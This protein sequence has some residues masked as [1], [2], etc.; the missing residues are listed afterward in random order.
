MA[1]FL[2][3][4]LY[5]HRNETL[6]QSFFFSCEPPT[7]FI[8][9]TR[10]EPVAVCLWQWCRWCWVG[11]LFTYITTHDGM[12]TPQT[13]RNVSTPKNADTYEQNYVRVDRHSTHV[14]SFKRRVSTAIFYAFSPP[15]L[16]I[17]PSLPLL[18]KKVSCE[19]LMVQQCRVA[20]FYRQGKL[21]HV[22]NSHNHAIIIISITITT[23]TSSKRGKPSRTQFR[24]CVALLSHSPLVSRKERVIFSCSAYTHARFTS[25]AMQ[26]A[27][28]DYSYGTISS[29]AGFMLPLDPPQHSEM[30]RSNKKSFFNAHI[31]IQATFFYFVFTSLCTYFVFSKIDRDIKE[32]CI[33][34][35]HSAFTHSHTHNSTQIYFFSKCTFFLKHFQWLQYARIHAFLRYNFYFILRFAA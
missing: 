32:P 3:S 35:Y 16:S 9:H 2:V 30:I 19:L 20:V 12:H 14:Y 18:L 8:L 6:T 34:I 10:P 11:V 26:L 28:P 15:L 1:K 17:Y 31:F 24:C 4:M 13:T 7:S 25:L 33:F 27:G 22:L 23:C 21:L 5:I 29:S